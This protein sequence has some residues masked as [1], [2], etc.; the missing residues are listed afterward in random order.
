VDKQGGL[1]DPSKMQVTGSQRTVWLAIII[2]FL[3]N[4]TK[5]GITIIS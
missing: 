1:V 2:L 3:V 5:S 4:V